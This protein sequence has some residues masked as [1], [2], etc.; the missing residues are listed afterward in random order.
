MILFNSWN[1]TTGSPIS[2]SSGQKVNKRSLTELEL[3]GVGDIIGFVEW[4]SLYY[5]D[6]VK[7]YPAEHPCKDLGKKNLVKQDN[8]ST[9]KMIGW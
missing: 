2:G 8:T 1:R 5:K 7:K 9:I 4:T 6:H 3:V